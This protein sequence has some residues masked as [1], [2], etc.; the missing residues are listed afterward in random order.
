MYQRP[1]G[2]NKWQP[3]RAA[4]KSRKIKADTKGLLRGLF[5]AV[6]ALGALAAL[7]HF[8]PH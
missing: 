1:Y 3:R 2:Y 8:G 7:I 6:L 4:R 5:A